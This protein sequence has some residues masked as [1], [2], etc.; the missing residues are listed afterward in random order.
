M[1]ECNCRVN[2]DRQKED[3]KRD[4][5]ITR[6]TLRSIANRNS[7]INQK[8]PHAIRQMPDRRSDPDQVD[9]ENRHDTE[10]ARDD[11]KSLARVARDRKRV[12]SRKQTKTKMEQVKGNEEKQDYAGDPLNRVEPIPR[13]WVVQVVRPRF[14]RDHQTVP[15]V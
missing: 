1:N 6:Q 9:D 3:A 4:T 2:A 10:F 13:I 12:E 7:P 5:S 15:G 11:L 8:Q 14:N